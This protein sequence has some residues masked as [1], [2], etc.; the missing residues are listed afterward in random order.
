VPPAP[1]G[2]VLIYKERFVVKKLLLTGA[3]AC[4]LM[5]SGV[6]MAGAMPHNRP[7]DKF[8]DRKDLWKLNPPAG[9]AIMFGL[10]GG[11]KDIPVEQNASRTGFWAAYNCG[12]QA[13]RERKILADNPYKNDELKERWSVGWKDARE[14][15]TTR[16]A[17]SFNV[18][19]IK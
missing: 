4:A 11:I 15:C 19:E 1:A 3:I 2:G 10:C 12:Y 16:A 18:P 7:C 14:F 17:S 6:T 13:Y 8:Q 9:N 5:T